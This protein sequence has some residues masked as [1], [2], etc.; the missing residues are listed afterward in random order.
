[1]TS[2]EKGTSTDQREDG[3]SRGTSPPLI[4]DHTSLHLPLPLR[5]LRAVGGGVG[6][7]EQNDHTDFVFTCETC[8][9][10]HDTHHWVKPGCAP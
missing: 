7:E 9:A 3:L 1:M 10:A 5:L 8:E 6:W 2:M 4:G